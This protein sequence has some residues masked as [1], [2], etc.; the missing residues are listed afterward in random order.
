MKADAEVEVNKVENESL[1]LRL[2]ICAP[3]W[4]DVEQTCSS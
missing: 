3:Q 4:D 2:L 1:K